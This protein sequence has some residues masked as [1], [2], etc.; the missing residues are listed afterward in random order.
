M[1]ILQVRLALNTLLPGAHLD[2][3]ADDPT[4]HKDILQFCRL[5]SITLVDHHRITPTLT[6]YRVLVQ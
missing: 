6:W 5:A 3:L 4:F 2:I 1:P